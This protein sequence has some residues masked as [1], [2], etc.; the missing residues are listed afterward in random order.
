MFVVVGGGGGGEGSPLG[1]HLVIPVQSAKDVHSVITSFT[2]AMFRRQFPA[3]RRDSGKWKM[4][5]EDW[6][7]DQGDGGGRWCSDKTLFASLET[8][9]H[10]GQTE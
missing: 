8:M 3:A 4:L 1:C 2:T 6:T 9:T 7:A 5:K 10:R